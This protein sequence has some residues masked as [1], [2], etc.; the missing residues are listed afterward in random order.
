[1]SLR[2]SRWR[3]ARTAAGQRTTKVA[4]EAKMSWTTMRS[5]NWTASVGPSACRWWPP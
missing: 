3:L 1:M 5:L 4:Y 2:R